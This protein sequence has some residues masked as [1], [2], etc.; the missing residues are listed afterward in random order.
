MIKKKLVKDSQ[1]FASLMAFK[2]YDYK[3]KLV[4]DSQGFFG[5]LR[6]TIDFLRFLK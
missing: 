3:K 4:K 1:V 2:K 5:S 6:K